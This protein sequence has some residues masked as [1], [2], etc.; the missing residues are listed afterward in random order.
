MTKMTPDKIELA[1][2]QRVGDKTVIRILPFDE[3]DVLIKKF[4]D[5]EKAAEEAKKEKEQKQAQSAKA[6]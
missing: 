5:A 3:V 1:T 2:L 4:E 6:K